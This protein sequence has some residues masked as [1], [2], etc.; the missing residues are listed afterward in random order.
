MI[1]CVAES[2][3][4]HRSPDAG[5]YRDVVLVPGADAAVAPAAFPDVG[6]RLAEIFA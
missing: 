2:G 6:L 3:E 1:D 4:V 5:G